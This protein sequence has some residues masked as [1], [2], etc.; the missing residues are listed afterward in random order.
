[1]HLHLHYKE[2]ILDYGP[3]YS[4]WCFSFERLNGILG[5][6]YT[7]NQNIEV[8]FMKKFLMHQQATTCHLPTGYDFLLVMCREKH[9]SGS[10]HFGSLNFEDYLT[11]QVGHV[12]S[13]FAEGTGL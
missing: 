13:S 12:T 1:M 5:D 11:S 10:L 8:Q 2:I 7:N 4:Y 9:N 6:Y 3:V